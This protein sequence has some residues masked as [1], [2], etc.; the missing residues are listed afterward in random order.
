MATE[1]TLRDYLK[2]TTTNLAEARQRV[3]ELEERSHEP[4]AVVGMGCRLPG[5][6]GDPEGLWD[7]VAGGV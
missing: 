6:V 2:W 1:D 7:V 4:L 5:G 3:Q